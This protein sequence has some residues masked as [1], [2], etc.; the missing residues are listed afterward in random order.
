MAIEVTERW[1]GY[2]LSLRP[3]WKATRVFDV[4]GTNDPVAAL[5]ATDT[6]TGLTIPQEGET[7][8]SDLPCQGPEITERK[9]PGFFVIT[10]TYGEAG[11]GTVDPRRPNEYQ[12]QTVE[13]NEPVSADID[14]RP[15]WNSAAD[16]FEGAYRTITFKRLTATRYEPFF[17]ITRSNTFENACNSAA[18]SLGA[19]ISIDV[20]K[21]RCVSIQ[22][23]SS[24]T[25]LDLRIPISY[26][27]DIIFDDSLGPYPFQHR[28]PNVGVNGWY[29]DSGTKRKAQFTDGKARQ[30]NTM[31]TPVPLDATGIPLSTNWGFVKLTPEN[32]TAVAS[33][34]VV[35]PYLSRTLPTGE[36][37]WFYKRTRLVNFAGLGL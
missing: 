31:Q 17:D 5:A 15:I 34:R 16:P 11:G 12:W 25:I 23:A 33:P 8:P 6:S 18:V 30:G 9:S 10:C 32:K 20:Q 13:V 24:Y 27:F 7:G 37:E 4:S 22:P 28:F 26:T 2:R 29:D 14:G 36:S 3:P 19:G 21:M 1:S 35:V